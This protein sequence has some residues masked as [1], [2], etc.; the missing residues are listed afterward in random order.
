MCVAGFKLVGWLVWGLLVWGLGV[1]GFVGWYL[2]VYRPIFKLAGIKIKRK[3]NLP[4]I[5][6]FYYNQHKEVLNEHPFKL[7]TAINYKP[8]K[9][10]KP[11]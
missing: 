1:W 11:L 6:I 8:H 5:V 4:G 9:P 7:L 3:F 2:L 10:H